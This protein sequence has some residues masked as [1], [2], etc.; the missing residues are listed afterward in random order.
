MLWPL[1]PHKV[2]RSCLSPEKNNSKKQI[3]MI[4]SK[5]KY[6]LKL[7]DFF[8]YLDFDY[9]KW[10]KLGHFTCTYYAP[11][12]QVPLNFEECSFTAFCHM[13]GFPFFHAYSIKW[14]AHGNIKCRGLPTS[15]F[16]NTYK[17]NTYNMLNMQREI[18]II[19]G[20]SSP[21]WP[22]PSNTVS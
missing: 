18:H 6:P 19:I 22:W 1:P 7:F 11:S 3:K 13:N 8:M 16:C 2:N 4:V 20:A 15:W 9:Q 14:H 5:L 17:P 21:S 12:I 10:Q